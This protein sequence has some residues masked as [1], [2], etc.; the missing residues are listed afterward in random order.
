MPKSLASGFGACLIFRQ[1]RNIMTT[2]NICTHSRTI[3][4]THPATL[5]ATICLYY[6]QLSAY[7]QPV[8]NPALSYRIPLQINTPSQCSLQCRAFHQTVSLLPCV[9]Q[10]AA[11][12]SATLHSLRSKFC[13]ACFAISSHTKFEYATGSSSLNP[14]IIIACAY[15][16]CAYFPN[17]SLS[18][19]SLSNASNTA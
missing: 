15:S 12:Q 6:M 19:F 11:R 13:Y 17:V 10:L 14:S 7:C 2:F 8:K 16:I 3:A 1:I 4:L 5:H 9:W 18:C